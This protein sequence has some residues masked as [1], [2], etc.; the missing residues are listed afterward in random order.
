MH[1]EDEDPK[2]W[3]EWVS[4]ACRATGTDPGQVDIEKT[5]HLASHV[6]RRVARPM[7]PVTAFIAGLAVGGGADL[8]AALKALEDAARAE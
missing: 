6:A 2:A 4:T 5:L 1:R 8:D 3:Q 7:V